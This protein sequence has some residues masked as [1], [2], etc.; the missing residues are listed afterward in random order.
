[1]IEHVDDNVGRILDKLS[2]L[3]LEDRTIV[4]FNSDNGGVTTFP[5]Y[6][7]PQV[8]SNSPLRGN[9]GQSTRAGSE[10]R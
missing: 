3:R 6:N 8:T 9:K 4:I 10:C 2:E 1:M 7:L 5:G